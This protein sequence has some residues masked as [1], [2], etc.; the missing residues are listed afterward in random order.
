MTIPTK[1]LLKSIAGIQDLQR[2]GQQDRYRSMKTNL[3]LEQFHWLKSGMNLFHRGLTFTGGALLRRTLSQ[4]CSGDDFFGS[5]K[6]EGEVW[7]GFSSACLFG[8]TLN[9]PFPLK[10]NHLRNVIIPLLKGRCF[11][12]T[13]V[14]IILICCKIDSTKSS[15][16]EDGNKLYH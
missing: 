10:L 15:S 1:S 12:K 3:T 6:E 7:K 9:P 8:E 2:L 13:P 11:L 16:Q 14:I 5:Q 4:G